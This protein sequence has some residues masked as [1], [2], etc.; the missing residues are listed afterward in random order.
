MATLYTT[1]LAKMKKIRLE[2]TPALFIARYLPHYGLGDEIIHMPSLSP[3]PELLLS[4]KADLDWRKYVARFTLEM[5]RREDMKDALKRVGNILDSG[6]D[7]L[8]VCYEKDYTRCH[9]YLL[10]KH[11]EYCGY[12]WKEIEI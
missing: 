8:L 5:L 3:T 7:V 2:G 1:Y 11:F 12:S 9:R 10:A 6:T 4:Y